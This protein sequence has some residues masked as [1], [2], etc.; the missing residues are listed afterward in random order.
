MQSTIMSFRNVHHHGALFANFFEGRFRSFIEHK[1]WELPEEDGMEFDQYDTPQSRWIA[2]HDEGSDEVLGGF[3]LTPTT[4]ACGHYSYMIRDAQRDL[5]DGSIPAN[6]LWEEAPVD[7]KVW[8]CTR[9]FVDHGVAQ[10]RRRSLHMQ[11][12]RVMMN[13]ARDVGCEYLVALT[14]ANWTRWYGRCGLVA[15]A[16]GPIMEIG[17]GMFQCVSIDVRKSMGA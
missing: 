5:L 13:A 16:I 17:D 2:V 9:V 12:V 15:D 11:M 14:D 4:A 8:E 3:R 10:A 6:L 1:A 7:P